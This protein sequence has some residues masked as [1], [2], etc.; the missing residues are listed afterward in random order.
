MQRRNLKASQ[1][2]PQPPR[3]RAAAALQSKPHKQLVTSSCSF[4]YLHFF[5]VQNKCLLSLTFFNVLRCSFPSS[6]FIFG[7]Q[8]CILMDII[9]VIFR[10]S[11]ASNDRNKPSLDASLTDPCPNYTKLV[12]FLLRLIY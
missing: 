10:C 8:I 6:C 12:W 1:H 11:Q 4:H 3:G 7:S 2:Q 9:S 5:I